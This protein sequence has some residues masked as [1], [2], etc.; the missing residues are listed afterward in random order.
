M[1][2]QAPAKLSDPQIKLLQRA[3]N[4]GADGAPFIGY[5]G[6][7][8]TARFL[9][10]A[11][12]ADLLVIGG[13]RMPRIFGTEAGREW[14][15]AHGEPANNAGGELEQVCAGGI[16]PGF[17]ECPKCGATMDDECRAVGEKDPGR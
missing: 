1:T 12:L 11:G 3:C 10:R 6:R 14:M 15:R 13:G 16:D 5:S 4:A 8:A 7:L 2:E 9:T 17:G